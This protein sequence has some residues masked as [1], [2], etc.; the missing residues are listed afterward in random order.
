MKHKLITLIFS[1]ALIN[2]LNG[3]ANVSYREC[4]NCDSG[5]E[6]STKTYQYSSTTTEF[7]AILVADDYGPRYKDCCAK[8]PDWHGGVDFN[9]T[10]QDLGDLIIALDTGEIS[11]SLTLGYKRLF[12]DSG[13]GHDFGYGHLFFGEQN[14]LQSGGCYLK[15]MIGLNIDDW[16]IIIVNGDT[17]AFGPDAGYVMFGG[18]SIQVIDRIENI[19]DPIG[20]IG[21]SVG[22]YTDKTTGQLY[23]TNLGAHLHLY[24]VP[25]GSNSTSD[26][27]TKNPL[28]Y[29]NYAQPTIA[30]HFFKKN[31]IDT[32]IVLRYPGTLNSTIQLRPEMVGM[33]H[34]VKRYGN[35]LDVNEVKVNIRKACSLD[36]FSLI[37]GP[38]WESRIS[39]GGRIGQTSYPRNPGDFIYHKN[40]LKGKIHRDT[41]WGRTGIHPRAYR[42][43]LSNSYPWDDYYLADFVTR[44]HKNDVIGVAPKEMAYNNEQARYPDG[45]YEFRAEIVDVRD[46]IVY[47]DTLDVII[48]NYKPYL[49]SLDVYL[50]DPTG[51]FTTHLYTFEMAEGG[52]INQLK[53][54]GF[55]PAPN[56]FASCNQVVLYLQRNKL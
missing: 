29:V 35:V 28:Q 53:P 55:S 15:R 54:I 40:N 52:C 6:T 56:T 2:L 47:G 7:P 31:D 51:L 36:T 13:N 32:G 24:S 22:P 17:T 48:D 19:G 30:T 26:A 38:T 5:A 39:L 25:A 1:M 46:T 11:G 20:P 12:V 50:Q 49:T 14:R 45:V 37:Q 42:G 33:P 4:T 27:I 41:V 34:Q 43:D 16:A 3:Q 8:K 44:I 23:G 18:D 9:G 10:G 21:G